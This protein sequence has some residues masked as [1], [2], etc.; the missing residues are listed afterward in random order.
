MDFLEITQIFE[1]LENNSK[2]LNK[3]LI[4]RDFL[5]KD[6]KT[7]QLIFDMI[8]G[9]FQRENNKKSIGISLKT[10]FS[11]ISFLS[12]KTEIQVEKEFN[13]IGDVGGVAQKLIGQSKQ[14]SLLTS[15]LTLEQITGAL[16]K[17][18]KTSGNNSNKIKKEIL[19]NLFLNA[20]TE[21]EYKFLARLLIDDLRIGVSE[22]VLREASVNYLFP[23]IIG[24]HN[25]C[26][27]CFYI[28]L[29]SK[30][31]L[32]C[33]TIIEQ[34]GQQEQFEN[35]FKI[36]EIGILPNNSSDKGLGISNSLT[37]KEIIGLDNSIEK[38][39]EEIKQIEIALKLNPKTH[40]IYNP[41]P[42]YYYK[43]F[44]ENFEKKYNTLNSFTDIITETKKD[45][46][47]ILKVNIKYF[48]PIK[49][50]LGV[51][52]NTVEH[53]FE[54]SGMPAVLDYKYDGLRVQ[55]HSH[56]GHIELFSR[57]LDNITKQF[58]EV[59]EFVK[60][61]F[62]KISFVLDSETVGYD[63]GTRKYLPFQMLSKR[64]LAK[65]IN[66]VNHIKVV[67]KAFDILKL[68]DETL[69]DFPYEKR[70]EMLENI[71]VNTPIR[72][73]IKFDL[74]LLKKIK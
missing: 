19:G 70:R 5:E 6:Q 32:N 72:E 48:R 67:V 35:R 12:K 44:L 43:K 52:S 11:V 57:N 23:K 50:M 58:P 63:F 39:K 69:V 10:L 1:K 26:N 7:G 34:T 61:N 71:F 18:S 15:K 73:P 49:S 59:L 60:K 54:V 36:V 40:I 29:N 62:P 8:C 47:S 51:R 55:I 20:T 53:S 37:P 30:N 56:N 27:K 65:N 31:C 3:I 21:I 14:G 4:L 42:R 9:N 16:Q 46:T 2:R 64:I 45:L 24:I 41:E 68:N 33:D 28:N 22:G 74:E 25:L 66:E 17:I 13:K 38:E